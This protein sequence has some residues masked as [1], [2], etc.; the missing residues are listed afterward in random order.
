MAGKLHVKPSAAKLTHDTE[1]LGRM[2]P[3]VKVRLDNSEKSTSVNSGGGKFPSWRNELI[4]DRSFENMIIFQVWDSDTMSSDDL[5]GEVTVPLQS[6]I[7]KRHTDEWY[8][9]VYK[10]KPAG[11]LRVEMDWKPP[12]VNMGNVSG[13]VMG[14]MPGY[15][16]QAYQGGPGMGGAPM[17]PGYSQPYPGYPP[18]G[19]GYTGYPPQGSPPGPPGYAPQGYAPQGYAPQ[20]YPPQNMPPPAYGYPPNNRNDSPPKTFQSSPPQGYPPQP[21][22]PGPSYPPGPQSY[23]SLPPQG[24]PSRQEYPG[25][26]NPYGAPPNPGNP[27]GAPPRQEYPNNPNPYG[28]PPRQEIP[29]NP[30]FG[31]PPNQ[32]I[33][34]YPQF[35]NDPHAQYP[36]APSGKN[37]GYGYNP[38]PEY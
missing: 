4:F 19:G 26:P 11:Q 33:S 31:A 23:Q 25:N 35:G 16:N 20:G 13:M 7:D 24:P 30:N 8:N 5:V 17:N 15:I 12:T 3:Y 22:Q 2:D 34:P 21:Y 29:N 14:A 37:T 27:Y 32:N 28:A 36:P 10:G 18:Q 38:P 6:T 1:F 9:L